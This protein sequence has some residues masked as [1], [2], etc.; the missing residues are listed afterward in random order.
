VSNPYI[1]IQSSNAL[2]NWLASDTEVIQVCTNNKF[3]MKH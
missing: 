1:T 3:Q 2:T